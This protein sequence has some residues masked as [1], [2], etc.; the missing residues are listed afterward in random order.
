MADVQ[1]VWSGDDGEG[2]IPGEPALRP[3]TCSDIVELW[4]CCEPC[5]KSG[6]ECIYD[7]PTPKFLVSGIIIAFHSNHEGHQLEVRVD[8][9][10]YPTPK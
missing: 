5:K 4:I 1:G 2:C 3:C 8:G 6:K 10:S 9:E 7:K